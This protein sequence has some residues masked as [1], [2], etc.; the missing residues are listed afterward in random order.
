VGPKNADDPSYNVILAKAGIS[1]SKEFDTPLEQSREIA[2]LF[3]YRTPED[4]ITSSSLTSI[5]DIVD[6][7]ADLV[8]TESTKRLN[9]EFDWKRRPHAIGVHADYE[10]HIVFST[11]PW[12]SVDEFKKIREQWV[13]YQ[14]KRPLCI[15]SPSD[16][17]QFETYFESVLMLSGSNKKYLSRKDSDIVRLRQTLCSARHQKMW[18]LNEFA[19]DKTSGQIVIID[20]DEKFAKLLTRAGIS[21]TRSDVENGSKSKR[22]LSL[23]A[24]PPTGRCRAAVETLCRTYPKLKPEEI[25]AESSLMTSLAPKS[26]TECQFV[27]R[28]VKGQPGS[29]GGTVH[30]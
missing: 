27:M 13:E 16:Y 24:C 2:R 21:A 19:W 29:F 3:F 6:Y 14:S 23:N 18:D 26:M 7:D 25:F 5:R 11:L 4:K 9:M 30:G 10:N 28:V 22:S 1:L 15:K 20:T 17:E 12:R 8:E